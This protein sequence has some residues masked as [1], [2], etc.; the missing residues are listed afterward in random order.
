MR[1]A[2]VKGLLKTVFISV[3]SIELALA[4]VLIPRLIVAGFDR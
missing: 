3:I 2:D 4:A 1:L